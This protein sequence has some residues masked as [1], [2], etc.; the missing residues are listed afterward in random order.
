MNIDQIRVTRPISEQDRTQLASLIHF[1]TFVHRHL[2]WRSPLDWIG[3]PPYYALE[4]NGRLIASLAC[5]PDL[6]EIAWVR[7][8]VCST[9]ISAQNAW[10]L[11]WPP[12]EEDLNTQDVRSLSAIP[13][14]KWFREL[15][16]ENGFK[17]LHNIV[18]LAWDNNNPIEKPAMPGYSLRIMRSSDLPLVEQ[19]DT[20]SFEP[21]WRH[22]SELIELAFSQA[23]IATV[24]EM[25]GEVVGYQ[26][27]T[28]AQYG[29]HLGRLAVDPKAQRRGIGFALL[30]DL[31]SRFQDGEA[32]LSVNTHDNNEKSLG[33]Y[34][35]AGFSK[36]S[37]IY[38]VYQFNF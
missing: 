35:K 10:E 29:G 4:S 19:I 23:A 15:L 11:L 5:S 22:S 38:P 25:D 26:I 14:Q 2:D 1:S 32:R 31:Q 9:A 6:P 36:T 27:T 17:R 3:H 21:L 13:I 34:Y 20:R 33:L 8:F 30:T 16:E 24:A 12:V 18:T 7:V 37:E 28:A